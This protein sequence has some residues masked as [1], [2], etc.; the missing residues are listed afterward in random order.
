MGHDVYKTMSYVQEKENKQFMSFGHA[1]VSSR[2]RRQAFLQ[3]QAS[4]D[5]FQKA[6]AIGCG[7]HLHVQRAVLGTLL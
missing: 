5:F 2:R 3:M 7:T 6:N 4:W 1:L